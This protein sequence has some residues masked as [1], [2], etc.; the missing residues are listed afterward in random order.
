M[1]KYV[2]TFIGIA[3]LNLGAEICTSEE[4]LHTLA[5]SKNNG[6][7]PGDFETHEGMS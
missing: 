3:G 1:A 5:C 6:F 2:D 4:N 7:Y